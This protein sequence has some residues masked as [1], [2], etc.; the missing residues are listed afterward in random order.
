MVLALLNSKQVGT[1]TKDD[2]IVE[3]AKNALSLDGHHEAS[4]VNS[5]TVIPKQEWIRK[6]TQYKSKTSRQGSE[7]VRK[8]IPY[9][10]ASYLKD[11]A[12]AK[13]LWRLFSSIGPIHSL[14]VYK[15]EEATEWVNSSSCIVQFESE[16]VSLENGCDE[17]VY[18]TM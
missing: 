14:I 5:L 11:G 16:I 2:R 9:L 18:R 8:S 4:W 17:V 1:C 6:K 7:K 15:G 3:G 10:V 13:E 12:T